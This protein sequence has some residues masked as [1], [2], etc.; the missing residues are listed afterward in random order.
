MDTPVHP[1]FTLDLGLP[2]DRAHLAF[3]TLSLKPFFNPLMQ[4]MKLDCWEN[5]AGARA[6]GQ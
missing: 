5:K 6:L 4:K 1:P 2:A 3:D